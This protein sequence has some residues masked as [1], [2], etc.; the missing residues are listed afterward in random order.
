[1]EF[2]ANENKRRHR[3]CELCGRVI[4]GDR[5]WAGRAQHGQRRKPWGV[6]AVHRE[7]REA[8]C[9]AGQLP[10]LPL[11]GRPADPQR[12]ILGFQGLFTAR[13]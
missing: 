10:W 4:I 3:V 6:W 8:L 9:R 2:D 12:V 1:M 5:E 7:Q 11:P 13:L